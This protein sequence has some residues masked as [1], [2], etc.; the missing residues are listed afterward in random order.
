MLE[1]LAKADIIKNF[2]GSYG[3]GEKDTGSPAV[4][5]ALLTKRINGLRPHFGRHKHDYHSNRGLMK[6]IGQRKSL[7]RYMQRHQRD[8]YLKLIK[9]L[10]LRK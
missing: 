3:S 6:M 10:G 4:Q 2:G 7:L 9:E 5:V 1:E 8:S